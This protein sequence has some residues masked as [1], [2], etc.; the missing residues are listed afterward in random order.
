[1]RSSASGCRRIAAL[2]ER[3]ARL[4]ARR[5]EVFGRHRVPAA[6]GGPGDDDAQLHPRD[7]VQLGT[8]VFFGFNVQFG[9][10]RRSKLADVFA[11][12]VRDEAV[13]I[14]RSASGTAGRSAP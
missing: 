2:R 3:A 1:M 13:S 4:D 5:Q 6:A 10:K 14:S 11:I 7:M 12:Y 9:L 8:P